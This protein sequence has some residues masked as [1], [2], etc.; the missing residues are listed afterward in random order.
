MTRQCLSRRDLLVQGD[1]KSAGLAA[2]GSPLLGGVAAYAAPTLL[3]GANPVTI[4]V[5]EHQQLRL[6]LLRAEI[7][8]FEAAM[9]VRGTPIK[10]SLHAGPMPDNDF[11]T[12]LTVAYAAERTL[13]SSRSFIPK[14]GEARI[15]QFIAEATRA[16]IDGK[17]SPDQAMNTFAAN[18]TQALGPDLVETM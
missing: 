17:A 4:T 2:T 5:L 7:P 9:A 8:R 18:V 13:N 10:V 16:L 3:P 15:Q 6:K 11:Q 12:Q 1:L 14:P